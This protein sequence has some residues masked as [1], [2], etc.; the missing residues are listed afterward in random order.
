MPK[1]YWT[2]EKIKSAKYDEVIKELKSIL[3]DFHYDSDTE[4][5]SKDVVIALENLIGDLK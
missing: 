1:Q 3:K 2:K 4:N 5:M